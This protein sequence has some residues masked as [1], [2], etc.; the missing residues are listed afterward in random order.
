MCRRSVRPR[1]RLVI[2]SADARDQGQRLCPRLSNFH[3]ANREDFAHATRI[4]MMGELTTSLV[5][6]INQ[7][8]TA[9]LS[10]AQAV[11]TEKNP[12]GQML[13]AYGRR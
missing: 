13:S 1:I 2:Q 5:H 11:H 6:E 3:S 8:L 9:T 12:F 7:P 10:N 4:A